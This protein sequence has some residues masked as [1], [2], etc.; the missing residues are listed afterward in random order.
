MLVM[1]IF[2]LILEK[3]AGTRKATRLVRFI[4]GSSVIQCRPS[5]YTKT[6]NNIADN[7][8]PNSIMSNQTTQPASVYDSSTRLTTQPLEARRQKMP[9]S[10]R[11]KSK[12]SAFSSN[13]I[14]TGPAGFSLRWINVCFVPAFVALPLTD[15]V[16][17]AEAF[18]IAGAFV[19][20]FLITMAISVYL[21]WALQKVIGKPRRAHVED[22]GDRVEITPGDVRNNDVIELPQ[23]NTRPITDVAEQEVRE[24]PKRDNQLGENP[25]FGQYPSYDQ[26]RAHGE[27]DQ[28]QGRRASTGSD[29]LE[30]V[31]FDSSNGVPEVDI[32]DMTSRPT[33][34]LGIVETVGRTELNSVD[35]SKDQGI[36]QQ[37]RNEKPGQLQLRSKVAHVVASRIDY[38]FYT[39]LLISGV[40]VYWGSPTSYAMP[41]QLSCLV[42]CFLAAMQVPHKYRVVFHPILI[43]AILCV[44]LLYFMSVIYTATIPKSSFSAATISQALERVGQEIDQGKVGSFVGVTSSKLVRG[45]EELKEEALKSIYKE[46]TYAFPMLRQA[47]WQF[48]TGQN[49][50]TMFENLRGKR[51]YIY[52]PKRGQ[53]EVA[54]PGAGDVISCLLDTSIVALSVPMFNY[55]KDLIR[56]VSKTKGN[57][58]EK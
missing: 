23:F 44:G 29:I 41:A 48:K 38:I 8:K 19:F 58:F 47:L 21:V 34:E 16:T 26:D 17:A 25:V 31:S 28:Q 36:K 39:S 50:Q 37:S 35:E 3:V 15:K 7:T 24:A 13:L 55:R 10:A 51:A 1:F 33:T 5:A 45:A 4:E 32:A 22:V 2:F 49:Y 52:N 6:N 12:L 57:E 53:F 43:S 40:C 14:I 27:I 18:E 46:R 9:L 56:N 20:G 30:Q 54:L 11:L 42:L